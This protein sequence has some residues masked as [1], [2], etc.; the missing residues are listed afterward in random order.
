MF[1]KIILL[2]HKQAQSYDLFM[3]R[4]KTN[5]TNLTSL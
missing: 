4:G 3:K 5:L 1:L 2:W